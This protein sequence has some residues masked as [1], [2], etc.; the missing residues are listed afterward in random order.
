MTAAASGIARLREMAERQYLKDYSSGSRAMTLE[1]LKQRRPDCADD[2]DVEI[3][4]LFEF[5][6]EVYALACADQRE[7][8]AQIAANAKIELDSDPRMLRG[9][10]SEGCWNAACDRI[11]AQMRRGDPPEA[12][13]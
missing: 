8:D 7:R 3:Y 6:Q 4:A 12:R 13:P 5:A 9:M 2:Y 10:G 11:A 1:T